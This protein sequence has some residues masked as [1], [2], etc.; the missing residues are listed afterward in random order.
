MNL[1]SRLAGSVVIGLALAALTAVTAS[2]AVTGGPAAGPV[3][4]GFQP[5][6]ATFVSA[7]DGWVLGTAPCAHAPCTSVLRT[8]DGG[9]RWVGIPAPRYPLA[10]PSA[11]GLTRMRF[12]DTSDGFAF[13]THLWATHDGGARWHRVR[14]VPGSILDLEASAGRVYAAALK[15]GRVTVYRSPAGR[16]D[17]S[18]V[19]G[20]PAFAGYDG[21]PAG[22]GLITLHGTAA[23]I[24]AG[25]RFYASQ[26]GSHWVRQGFRCPRLLALSS[27]AAYNSQ[28]IAV[29]CSGDPA[30]GST[31]KVLYAS[32]D[33][34]KRFA[35]VGP[36]PS[37]GDGGILAEPTPQHLAVATSSGATWVYVSTDGGRR[38]HTRLD[39]TDGG[40]GWFDFGFTTAT[41]GFALEGTP[42]FGSHLYMTS[43]GGQTWHRV[44]F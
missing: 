14:Q 4:A 16:D 31:T 8:T 36:V 25:S 15:S 24:L 9:R 43:N 42:Q 18:R 41:Q 26:T 28:R 40:K 13:G 6:S 10:G 44:R 19:A 35:K 32:S 23:W 17:W 3:P 39:L 2:A 30:A 1:R 7:N 20:L 33:G 21:G 37:G 27:L 22:L 38:W 5:A 11:R 29:L 12:A 34:G